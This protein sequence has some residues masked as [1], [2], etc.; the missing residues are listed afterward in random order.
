MRKPSWSSLLIGALVVGGLAGCGDK[1]S[2]AGPATVVPGVTG[3][4][5]TPP[6][7][8]MKP[9]EKA[10]LSAVVT[11]N[12]AS[13][14]KTVTWTSNNTAV[15][16]VAT[17][18]EV[19]AVAAG[20]ATIT[21]AATADANF[22]VTAQVLVSAANKGVR[23]VTI[24]P[25]SATLAPTQVL[26]LAANVDADPN[27]ARTVTWATNN[28]GVATVSATGQVTAVSAGAA[29]IT[30][31][32][33]VDTSIFANAPITVRQ[34]VLATVSIQSI[35]AGG[36]GAP[37]NITNTFGQIDVTINVEANDEKVNSVDLLVDNTVVGSQVFSAAQVSALS[38]VSAYKAAG[39]M[40]QAANA[41]AAAAVPTQIVL[42]FRTDAFDPA[43]GV[44]SFLNGQH[45]IRAVANTATTKRASNTQS[46]FFN[47]NDGFYATLDNVPKNGGIKS[48]VSAGG[49]VW[50]QGDV[51][52]TTVPVFYTPTTPGGTTPNTACIRT[53]NF[54]GATSVTVGTAT[55]CVGGAH[56]D[57]LVLAQGAAGYQSNPATPDVPTVTGAVF[58]S[59]QPVIFNQN[60]AAPQSTGGLINVGVQPPAGV[61]LFGLRMDNLSPVVPVP[62]IV[63]SAPAVTGWVNAAFAFN[64]SAYLASI[65]DGTGVGLNATRATHYNY[66][67]CPY[68]APPSGSPLPADTRV[69]VAFDGT[70]N[71]IPECATDFTGGATPGPYAVVVDEADRLNNVGRSAETARFGVDKTPPKHRFATVTTAPG[72]T[73]ATPN[74][75]VAIAAPGAVATNPVFITEALDDRS[76]FLRDAGTGLG[77]LSQSLTSANANNPTGKCLIAAA[78]TTPGATFITNPGCGLTTTSA[79]IALTALP[80]GYRQG[81]VIDPVT[82]TAAAPDLS[83][84][85]F[86]YKSR[87]TDQAGN[88]SVDATTGAAGVQQL[89]FVNDPA[90]PVVANVNIPV[91]ITAA[92]F[93]GFTSTFSDDVEV[94]GMSFGLIYPNVA[95]VRYPRSNQNQTFDDLISSPGTLN[96]VSP[97]GLPFVRGME[98]VDGAGAVQ[99]APQNTQTKP[100]AAQ[101]EVFDVFGQVGFSPQTVI[102]GVVV[103]NGVTFTAFNAANPTSAIITWK[104]PSLA[105]GFFAPIGLKAQLVAPLNSVNAPFARVDFY[106]LN[107]V[108]GP[109]GTPAAGSEYWY[110][111]SSSVAINADNGINR[112]WTYVAPAT[113]AASPFDL[114]AQSAAAATQ[115]IIA[116][117]VTAAGDGL[118]TTATQL[119]P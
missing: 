68:I 48:A 3:I 105:A 118:A 112:F 40:Q 96:T 63:R 31:T 90:A 53:V 33:T 87:W 8:S 29:N 86:V 27:V 58:A 43:T 39:L 79:V 69:F 9:G 110:I 77:A 95:Q 18:G 19:T 46:L 13:V 72:F 93:P 59:N 25:P 7:L 12:D 21:A 82:L 37:V 50:N 88:A 16:T 78:G 97:Y 84:G 101:T 11:T 80:D 70:G 114:T 51:I 54:P 81:P 100:T 26:Q 5:I 73:P 34:L 49:I 23:N 35:T 116:V 22:K 20:S 94:I 17:T 67:G 60:G 15:A 119:V 91:S 117:G 106:R 24:N 6:S 65:S 38:V 74:Q 14:A 2:V 89:A 102:P 30:A 44:V 113:L 1:V 104:I 52:V 71:T 55:A 10:I 4:T 109:G 57:T 75:I 76:G 61:R 85:Y 83:A 42:S 111:G 115:F 99:G 28:A 36:L 32:S 56:T 108:A 92:T 47:N 45:T 62:S 41:A 98:I 107:T 66:Q 64:P 103:Q